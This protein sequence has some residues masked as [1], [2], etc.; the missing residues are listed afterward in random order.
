MP[1]EASA[2]NSLNDEV[3]RGCRRSDAGAE[4]DLPLGRNIQVGNEEDLLL[5]KVERVGRGDSS[6]TSIIFGPDTDGTV[7]VVPDLYRRRKTD[8]LIDIRSMPSALQCR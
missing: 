4:V 3:I 1:G 7:Q 2:N 6:V 8:A 5:L